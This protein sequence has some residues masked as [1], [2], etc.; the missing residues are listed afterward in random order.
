LIVETPHSFFDT[1]TLEISLGVFDA[2]QARALLVNTMHRAGNGSKIERRR[3]ARSGDSPFDV[4]HVERSFFSSAHGAL[5]AAA[6]LAIVVQLHGYRDEKVPG[7]DVIVSAANTRAR[8]EPLVSALRAVLDPKRVRAY[9]A[10]VDQLG[11]TTNVQA[12][13]SAKQK[14]AFLHVEMSTSLRQ[15]LTRDANLA[16][17]FFE[18]FAEAIGRMQ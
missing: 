7:V 3:L 17:R 2:L 8:V 10:E 1:G 18:A 15:S 9:P 14:S 5:I 13:A 16:A 11:G 6:P 12:K 4:A